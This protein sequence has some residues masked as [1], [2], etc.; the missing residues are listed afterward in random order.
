MLAIY[1]SEN[2]NFLED[3]DEDKRDICSQKIESY[4]KE[5]QM[6]KKNLLRSR[7]ILKEIVIR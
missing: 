1:S 4:I 3:T 6:D 5:K 2:M 7:A